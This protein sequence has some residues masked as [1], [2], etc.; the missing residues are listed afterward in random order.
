MNSKWQTKKTQR[1]FT[2]RHQKA[3]TSQRQRI[4]WKCVTQQWTAPPLKRISKRKFHLH[5]T[6]NYNEV[7]TVTWLGNRHNKLIFHLES[8][9]ST[10]QLCFIVKRTIFGVHDGWAT[11]NNCTSE[12]LM[13][14]MLINFFLNIYLYGSFLMD[15][16]WICWMNGVN[17]ASKYIGNRWVVRSKY[18]RAKWGF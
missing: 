8:I 11:A 9:F 5:V 6:T 10:L 16:C 1:F 12:L 3:K 4:H 2:P 14:S 7:L 18:V 13:L 17:G 15:S